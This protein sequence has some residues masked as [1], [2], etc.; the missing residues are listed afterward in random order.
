MGTLRERTMREV[1][2]LGPAELM[3][4]HGLIDALKKR[5]PLPR[6]TA[7]AGRERARAA[8]SSLKGS[9]AEVIS[10]DRDDRV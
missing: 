1:E 7:G 3:A 10:T 8:L 6:P 5:R 2:E 9:L 4:V